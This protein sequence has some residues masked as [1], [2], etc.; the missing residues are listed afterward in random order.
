MDS[1]EPLGPSPAVLAKR[2]K[3]KPSQWC[4]KVNIE[5]DNWCDSD[6]PKTILPNDVIKAA[7][8]ITH[9]I[10]KTP[11]TKSRYTTKLNMDLY[12]KLEIFHRTGS[13]SERGALYSLKMLG[14][15]Q[16]K[17]GV[18]TASLGN[19]AMALAY[20]GCKLNI[21][22]TVVLPVYTLVSVVEKCKYFK[23]K[24]ILNGKNLAESKRHAFTILADS[25]KTYINGYDH[26]HVIAGAGT[27]G[28]EILEQLPQIDAILV[29]VG[30]GGLI[31]GIAAIV[32]HIKPEVLIY[33]IEPVKCCSFFKAMENKWPYETAVSRSLAES[34]AVPTAGYNAYN[35]AQ[36]MID[37]MVLVDDDWITRA[38]LHL[39]E[40]EK[41][42]VEGAGAVSMSALLA[43]PEII[44]ELREK[45]V[46]CL[47]TG[48]NIDAV[49][50]PKCLDRAKAVEGRLIKLTVALPVDGMKEQVQIL[51]IIANVGCNIVR[52]YYER[53]WTT[54]NEF[55]KIY[56]TLLIETTGLEKSCTL[57]RVMERLFPDKCKFLEEP[58]SPIPMCACF[59]KR[60]C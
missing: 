8:A 34:L 19:W 28:I 6:N 13:F 17:I 4:H 59:P 55:F 56:L 53:G 58:F 20:Y 12:Y 39:V 60:F 18:I 49:T 52:S 37:K 33:G 29:P 11:L 5:F 51:R 54:G 26:P 15:E 35:T 32:K 25:G 30:G 41:I 10:P 1:K 22:V 16:R 27:I 36:S 14:V 57:K 9:E 46:V 44:P 3:V 50:L 47:I 7:A 42:V 43:V 24:V 21:P 23:A 48:G 31:A 45:T 40:S 2:D 38:V